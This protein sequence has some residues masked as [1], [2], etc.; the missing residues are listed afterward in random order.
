MTMDEYMKEIMA[1]LEKEASFSDPDQALEAAVAVYREKEEPLAVFKD[2]S[3]SCRT[4]HSENSESA[5]RA[6]YRLVFDFTETVR[7]A[8]SDL[9]PRQAVEAFRQA[10]RDLH[11]K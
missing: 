11:K 8:L 6:G 2:P 3:G 4:I 7:A 5:I 9:P 10:V 1:E